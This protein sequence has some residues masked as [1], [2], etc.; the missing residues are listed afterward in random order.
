MVMGIYDAER[1]A[2]IAEIEQAFEAAMETGRGAALITQAM[3]RPG[4][5]GG[6]RRCGNP[7]STI[8]SDTRIRT[9]DPLI[10]S[11]LLYR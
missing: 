1:D 2:R 5:V 6:G 9:W 7:Y 10:N 3:T 4:S 11:Q 8:G